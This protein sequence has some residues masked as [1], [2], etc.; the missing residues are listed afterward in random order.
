MKKRRGKGHAVWDKP[1]WRSA[2]RLY[3]A[4]RWGGDLSKTGQAA[5]RAGEGQLRSAASR[6]KDK[7]ELGTQDSER[8]AANPAVPH[9]SC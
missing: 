3:T 5:L 4:V 1:A 7:R 8:Q 9:A 2:L 6:G